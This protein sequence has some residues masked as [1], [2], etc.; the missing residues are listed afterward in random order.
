M[1]KF[2]ANQSWNTDTQKIKHHFGIS[3]KK[4]KALSR[5]LAIDYRHI[6]R[7]LE[8]Q[9]E[10]PRA[11]ARNPDI[12]TLALKNAIDAANIH[13]NDL[14]YL[15]GHTASPAQ[16]MPPNIAE[17]AEK[18]NF[19]GPTAELRRKQPPSTVLT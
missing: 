8:K 1:V 18:L 16:L 14:Q 7:D 9:V 2:S 5:L 17:V 13:S 12:A 15:I 6:S 19:I 3:S 4:G 10:S 11:G